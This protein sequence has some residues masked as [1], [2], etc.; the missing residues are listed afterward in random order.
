MTP[1]EIRI[2]V[3]EDALD[4]LGKEYEEHSAI[5]NILEDKAQKTATISG[6]LLAAGLGFTKSETLIELEAGYSKFWA[7]VIVVNTVVL[8]LIAIGCCL[9]VLWPRKRVVAPRWKLQSMVNSMAALPDAE[10]DDGALARFLNDQSELWP[11]V[12]NKR[13]AL[14]KE[15]ADSLLFAQVALS[16]GF[17]LIALLVILAAEVVKHAR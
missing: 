12:L 4:A 3:Q 8:L 1:N 5:A 11:D 16:L 7:D 15:K 10:L 14:N 9:V 13:M 2:R 17:F 6:V